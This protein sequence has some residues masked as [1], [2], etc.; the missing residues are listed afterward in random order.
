M[1][2]DTDLT[3]TKA[4]LAR[5]AQ[6][7]ELGRSQF[8]R[9]TGVKDAHEAYVI[10]ESG[11]EVPPIT[12]AEMQGLI[13]REREWTCLAQSRRL[14]FPCKPMQLVDFVNASDGVFTIPEDFEALVR[15][16]V[17]FVAAKPRVSDDVKLQLLALNEGGQSL[18]ALAASFPINGALVEKSRIQQLIESAREI[19][20]ETHKAMSK[21]STLAGQ[22]GIKT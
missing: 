17:V 5:H 4:E 12:D 10:S 14:H 16:D 11:V 22:L 13:G 6:A 15:G 18:A 7:K 19:R 2:K 3:L 9:I 20:A 8:M 1:K 21:A